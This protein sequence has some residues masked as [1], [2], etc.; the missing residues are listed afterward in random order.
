MM[1]A[2]L[3][4]DLTPLEYIVLGFISVKSLSGYDIVTNF[5]A[6]LYSWSASPGSIYPMLKRLEK[7]GLISGE[8]EIEYETRPRKVYS[9]TE[10][11]GVL[12]DAWLRDLPHMRPFYTNRELA[13]LRFQFMETR[14]SPQEVLDWLNEY[15]DQVTVSEE[16]R[17]DVRSRMKAAMDELDI[18]QSVHA[19]L[20]MDG[21]LLD[22]NALRDWLL[23]A[24]DR[25]E[26]V[27]SQQTQPSEENVT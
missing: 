14:L 23:M 11:G 1:T 16:H 15:L 5:E 22:M 19:E 24:R 10:S 2:Q 9:L 4:R 8:L 21:V 12:L 26:Q 27:I 20:V 13:L 3:D 25:I 17:S 18:Q 6:G 7:Q